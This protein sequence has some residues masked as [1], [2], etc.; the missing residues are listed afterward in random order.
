VLCGLSV[1]WRC[2]TDDFVAPLRFRDALIIAQLC[3]EVQLGGLEVV[4]GGG[5]SGSHG[6]SGEG[7]C[8]LFG[9]QWGNGAKCAQRGLGCLGISRGATYLGEGLETRQKLQVKS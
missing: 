4:S 7:H 3:A 2:L 8:L 9:K 6:G 1:V 5:G